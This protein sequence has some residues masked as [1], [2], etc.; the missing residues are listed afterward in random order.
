MRTVWSAN[1]AALAAVTLPV[2]LSAVRRIGTK[3][4]SSV[5]TVWMLRLSGVPLAG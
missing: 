2:V 4:R 5:A 3:R 1:C